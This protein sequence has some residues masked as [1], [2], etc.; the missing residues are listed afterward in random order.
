M[1]IVSL[2]A[3]GGRKGGAL[4]EW[5]TEIDAD[6]YCLQ[7]MFSAP[8]LSDPFFND[9]D[10]HRVR[11]N[12]FGEF[13]KL[14]PQHN[15][16]FCAGSKGYVNDSQWTGLDVEYG[17]AVFVRRSLPVVAQQSDMVH[18]RF[19]CD[20]TGSPPLSRSGHVF[21]CQLADGHVTVG[22]I[23]GLWDPAG[24]HD[25]PERKAQARA[26]G[27]LIDSVAKPGDGIVACGDFNLLPNSATFAEMGRTE[28]RNL[29]S[30][31]EISSTRNSLYKKEN[32]FA[33][34]ALAN[35]ALNV[36]SFEVPQEPLISDHC[37]LIMNV[38]VNGGDA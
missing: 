14:L 20:S 36:T 21:R 3:W 2:N 16:Y 33:D 26:F 7:E 13:E 25:T 15:G 17:L 12:L 8:L 34:Y 35:S 30:E 5:I 24:K 18:G 31:F 22:N 23:H 27:S 6:I 19:R 38:Q 32:R 4:A 37:P 28:W 1:R 11:L 29:I 9:E 10:G